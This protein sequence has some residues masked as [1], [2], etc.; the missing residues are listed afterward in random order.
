[1]SP[2]TIR[3]RKH[4]TDNNLNQRANSKSRTPQNSEETELKINKLKA[5]GRDQQS[6]TNRNFKSQSET[7]KND[8]DESN[9]Q[10]DGEK[11]DDNSK[12]E[13]QS[14]RERKY[15]FKRFEYKSPSHKRTHS[16]TTDSN[17]QIDDTY[18]ED[19]RTSNGYSN[20]LNSRPEVN[21]NEEQN[22]IDNRREL[23]GNEPNRFKQFNKRKET[24]PIPPTRE[25]ETENATKKQAYL[26]RN[27]EKDYAKFK[28]RTEKSQDFVSV[29][30]PI[31][32][33]YELYNRNEG[34]TY[35]RRSYTT[36]SSNEGIMLLY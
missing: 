9:F 33:K 10:R 15:T 24:T 32:P 21:K 2:Q 31:K 22:S 17:I 30:T 28:T 26:P 19:K 13:E 4:E 14:Q 29:K 6:R 16:V 23:I 34:P 12:F 18:N 35:R 36:P 11:Q 20:S 7:N 25:A 5:R 3:Q 8:S 1:M 27:R